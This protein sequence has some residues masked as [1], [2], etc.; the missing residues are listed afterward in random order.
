MDMV[1]PVGEFFMR[2]SVDTYHHGSGF[3]KCKSIFFKN[4]I[5]FCCKPY[6]SV[7]YF[8]LQYNANRI[9]LIFEKGD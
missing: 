6:F 9:S 5:V 2:K 3:Y 7:I 4:Q 1:N 8:E